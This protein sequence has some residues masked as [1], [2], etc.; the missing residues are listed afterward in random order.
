[1][2]GGRTQTYCSSH[3]QELVAEL[4][5]FLAGSKSLVTWWQH[6][7]GAGKQAT[8]PLGV[9]VSCLVELRRECVEEEGWM[10]GRQESWGQA[11]V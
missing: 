3:S 10:K 11:C 4:F 1:M 7:S 5:V 6:H 2:E 9:S 8:F